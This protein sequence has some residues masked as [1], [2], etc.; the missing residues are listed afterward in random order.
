MLNYLIKKF[1]DDPDNIKNASVRKS[2][3]NLAGT[4][5]ILVNVVL[6]AIKLFIGFFTGSIA[7]ISDGFHNLVDVASALASIISFKLAGKEPDLEHPYGH[8]R[9]EYLF[10]IGVAVVVMAVGIQFLIESVE[11]ILYPTAVTTT[12]LTMAVFAA[13]LIGPL[14]LWYSYRFFAKKIDSQV[15]AAAGADSFSDLISSVVIL[16][17]LLL[18]PFIGFNLD[19]Y[20]GVFAAGLIVHTGY[21]IFK[22]S[23]SS[24]IGD[25]PSPVLVNE[26]TRFVRSYPGVLG[27]H[28]LMIHDYGPNSKFVTLHV[29]V[30]ADEDVIKTHEMIDGI[31]KDAFDKMGIN[32]TV[33]MDPLRRDEKTT[34]TYFHL[35]QL[36][37]EYDP[38][39]DIHDLRM[40]KSHDS[41]SVLFDLVVPFGEK[42]SHKQIR[43]DI[44]EIVSSI[45]PCY[46]ANITIDVCYTG[47]HNVHRK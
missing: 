38:N 9:L 25:E 43:K 13:S 30:D 29:E 21:G 40:I 11:K 17:G 33:H 2:Y 36:I 1:I 45:D 31:E 26:I 14:F 18:G 3:G 28:D 46:Q 24:L 27:L 41:I 4:I 20:L 7:I 12:N 42:K 32:L 10:S 44:A 6:S 37:K 5:G 34:A 8:G 35:Q 23:T 39:M 16:I 19:G 47:L 15:L 22:D